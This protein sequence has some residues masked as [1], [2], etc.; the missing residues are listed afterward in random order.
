MDSEKSK[1]AKD[2][3]RNSGI[4]SILCWILSILL[5]YKG[6]TETVDIC[7]ILFVGAIF[8]TYIYFSMGKLINEYENLEK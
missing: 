8:F 3:R 1:E 4:F 5:M 6:D 2:F 7:S